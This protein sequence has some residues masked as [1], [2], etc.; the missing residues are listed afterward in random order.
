MLRAHRAA[1]LSRGQD[2]ERYVVSDPVQV[3]KK[4][5]GGSPFQNC[6]T[7]LFFALEREALE[8]VESAA[9]CAQRQFEEMTRARLDRSFLAVLEL[10]RVIPAII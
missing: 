3:R 1:F 7:I 8:S 4:G 2:P 6:A 5:Q 10:M 9:A